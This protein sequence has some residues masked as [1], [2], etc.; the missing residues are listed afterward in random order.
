DVN[1]TAGPYPVSVSVADF[2]G[3]GKPD[4]AVANDG[5]EPDYPERGISVLLGDGDGAFQSA[6]R[7]GAAGLIPGPMAVSDFNGDGRVDAAVVERRSASVSVLLG[8]G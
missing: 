4:L 1:Y 3:N 5:W 7:S 6:V 2:N 8:K